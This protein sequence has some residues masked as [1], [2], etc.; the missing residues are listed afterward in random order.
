MFRPR[1]ES[2]SESQY[3]FT[4]NTI[5]MLVK[6]FRSVGT[7]NVICIGAPTI[8]ERILY[9]LPEMSSVL[10]DIDHRYVCEIFFLLLSDLMVII[11]NLYFFQLQFYES[12][13]FRWFNMYNCHML[14][15]CDTELVL[16]DIL[17]QG[18]S[19]AVFIDPPFGGRLE[20]LAYTLEKFDQIRKKNNK[21]ILSSKNLSYCI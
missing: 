5:E 12:D 16:E 11:F 7:T 6:M 9:N 19:T 8:H 2:K 21:S 13:H 10:L 1:Q 18:D 17:T 20:P 4:E 15:E 14:E 3:F